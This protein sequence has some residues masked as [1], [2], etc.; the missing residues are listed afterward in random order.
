MWNYWKNIVG[1]SLFVVSFFF[2]EM[3]LWVKY[4]NTRAVEIDATSCRN[5]NGLIEMVKHKL[6]SLK[7]VPFENITLHASE[8]QV[9]LRPGLSL[10]QLSTQPGYTVNDD[11]HPLIVKVIIPT[12]APESIPQGNFQF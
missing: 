9:A 4:L 8:N 1:F 11:D 2:K 5:V 12:A 10:S 6:G 3:Y 7:D